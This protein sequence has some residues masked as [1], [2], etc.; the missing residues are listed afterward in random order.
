MSTDRNYLLCNQKS[1]EVSFNALTDICMP[2]L[3]DQIQDPSANIFHRSLHLTA[4]KTKIAKC[5]SELAE[6]YGSLVS[7]GSYPAFHHNSYYRVRITFDSYQE[8]AVKSAYEEAKSLFHNFV[9]VY[10]P[11]PFSKADYEV[12]KLSEQK[13]TNLGKCVAESLKMIEEAL[14]KY[15]DSE[16]VICFNGGKDCT[17]LLHLIYA[18]VCRRNRQ[19]NNHNTQNKNSA[20]L[21]K[22]LYIRSN[23]TFPEIEIFVEKTI[24]VYYSSSSKILRPDLKQH[25]SHETA[26]SIQSASCQTDNGVVIYEGPIKNVLKRFL[27]DYPNIKGAFMGTRYSD[28]GAHN[29]HPVMMSDP[30]WPQILRIN[31]LLNWTYSD[32]WN[33]LRSLSLPYCRLYDVGYTSIGSMEDTHPNPQL[34]YITKTGRIAYH[35][36][37]M[38]EEENCERVGRGNKNTK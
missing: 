14:N 6:K 17:I 2:S 22:L 3:Q 26:V 37:Y 34:R 31:P 1:S 20:K 33:F 10:N 12:Y 8:G 19:D 30:G 13:E 38:L 23:S 5:L 16:L 32:V 18:S 36:A 29:I 27:Q 11:D 25:E 21:P 28:P 7:I 9:V 24:D 4:D 35:P 15:R